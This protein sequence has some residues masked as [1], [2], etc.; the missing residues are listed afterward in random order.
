MRIASIF[1]LL[2]ALNS[3]FKVDTLFWRRYVS[4]NA[5]SLSSDQASIFDWSN[6]PGMIM[7]IDEVDISAVGREGFKSA[8]LNPGVHTFKYSNYVHD[9]G[10]ING[11]LDVNLKPGQK[12]LFKFKTCYWCSPRKYAVW[13]INESSGEIVWGNLPSWPAWWL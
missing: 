5:S 10:H 1:I 4:P 11:K 3:C 9:F 8:R 2:M 13:V 6:T 7:N 12:Y